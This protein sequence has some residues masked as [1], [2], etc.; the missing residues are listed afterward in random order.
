MAELVNVVNLRYKKG[1]QPI[2]NNLN[3]SVSSG[4]II[5]LIGEN[6]VGK[7]TLM[8]L[9]AGIA[10][11]WTGEMT[12]E[13]LPVGTVTK[14]QVAFL[15][16]RADF[17]S[18]QR[19]KDIITFYRTFYQDFD[20]IR[21]YELLRYMDLNES[22]K[23][24]QLS[25]GMVEKFLLAITLARRAKLYLLDEP[26]SGID[27]LSREKIIQSLLQW[28]N[29]DS[30]IIITTHQMGE[31]ESILDEVM[32]LRS[33]EVIL[34]ESMEHIKEVKHKNLEGLYREIYG[35]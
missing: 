23:I 11:G 33:G 30:T 22:D 13:G 32:F 6:G 15:E 18:N 21:A 19:L 35:L 17:S 34:H 2:F 26:L 9:L 3:F 28:F 5:G 1:T 16:D 25:K 31:I 14:N 10:L 8:R 7:T 20:K 27:L 24:G 12:I 4:K 29:E